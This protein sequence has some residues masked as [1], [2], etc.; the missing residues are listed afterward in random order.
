MVIIKHYY[1]KYF[2]LII[3]NFIIIMN[4]HLKIENLTIN[5]CYYEDQ[6]VRID[7]YF[8]KFIIIKGVKNFFEKLNFHKYQDFIEVYK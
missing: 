4:Y 1:Y 5:Y 3:I 2:D 7:L 6:N 8:I